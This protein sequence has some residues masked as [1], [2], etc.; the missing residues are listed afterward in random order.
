MKYVLKI[1]N[2]ED[3]KSKFIWKI[4]KSLGVVSE[5][6]SSLPSNKLESF[7]HFKHTYD[8]FINYFDL[9]FETFSIKSSD[10]ILELEKIISLYTN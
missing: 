5:N 7:D 8:S 1:L 2:K 3:V 9:S 10:Q 4:L 6:E